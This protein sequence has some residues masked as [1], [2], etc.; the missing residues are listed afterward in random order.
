MKRTEVLGRCVE[1][2]ALI[3]SRDSKQIVS[4]TITYINKKVTTMFK[5]AHLNMVL[6]M[7][8]FA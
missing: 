6:A 2:D 7:T 3:R 8:G 4:D 5:A 1:M